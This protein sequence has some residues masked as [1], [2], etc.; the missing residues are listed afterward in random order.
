[1]NNT[2][3]ETA[4]KLFLA[5]QF[6]R[7]FPLFEELAEENNS[8]ALFFLGVLHGYGLGHVKKDQ[9]KSLTALEKSA[10]TG[11]PGAWVELASLLYR[12]AEEIVAVDE[13][14]NHRILEKATAGDVI[15][16]YELGGALY[17]WLGC[18]AGYR[19]RKY[20]AQTGG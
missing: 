20:V 2:K 10:V 7:A 14:L 5:C 17:Q 1:M 16:Q 15:S 18:G 11:E 13:T 9:E 19:R 12:R 8:R 3:L 4:E 6:D